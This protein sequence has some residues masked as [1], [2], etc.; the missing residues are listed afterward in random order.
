MLVGRQVLRESKKGLPRTL[1]C[2]RGASAA[3]KRQLEGTD[4]LN[5]GVSAGDALAFLNF[6]TAMT[7]VIAHV[8]TAACLAA[9]ARSP[10]ALAAASADAASGV[11]ASP[12][13]F[14]SAMAA[15]LRISPPSPNDAS[16]RL[17]RC[18]RP[19]FRN[20]SSSFSRPR[21]RPIA[22]LRRMA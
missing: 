20:P 5:A 17:A 7:R 4:P 14:V 8:T 19:S 12:F 18:A 10:F 21:A 6:S 15:R 13:A 1:K 3:E 2:A 9:N 16:A 22:R 11:S